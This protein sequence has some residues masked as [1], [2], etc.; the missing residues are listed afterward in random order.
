[1][2]QT[3]NH[4]DEHIVDASSGIIWLLLLSPIVQCPRTASKLGAEREL[5]ALR[6]ATESRHGCKEN[7]SPHAPTP[8]CSDGCPNASCSFLRSRPAVVRAACLP[9]VP[10]RPIR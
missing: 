9:L 8:Q 5:A 2:R 7:Y 3:T 6:A 1:M 4:A 10:S